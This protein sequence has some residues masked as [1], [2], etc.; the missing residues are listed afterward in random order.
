[1]NDALK[2]LATLYQYNDWANARLLRQAALVTPEQYTASAP[3]PHGSLRG[4]LVHSLGAEVAWRRRWQGDSPASLLNEGDLN[5][6][7]RYKTTRGLPK[8]NRAVAPDGPCG[9]PR[10]PAPLRGSHVADRRRALAG[11]FGLDRVPAGEGMRC[12]SGD[13]ESMSRPCRNWAR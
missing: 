13:F 12:C 6:T 1:M 10:R 11:R 8:E 4:T 2:W 7:I 3:V 9:Q 5:R